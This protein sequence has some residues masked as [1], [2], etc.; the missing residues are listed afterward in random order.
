LQIY[1]LKGILIP[2]ENPFSLLPVSLNVIRQYN[3]IAHWQMSQ[4]QASKYVTNS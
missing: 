1:W 2:Q 3:F 4:S